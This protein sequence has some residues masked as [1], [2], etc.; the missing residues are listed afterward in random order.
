MQNSS[1]RPHA[2]ENTVIVIDSFKGL[3]HIY[4]ANKPLYNMKPRAA[5]FQRSTI[6]T[7]C[8]FREDKLFIEVLS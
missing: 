4:L 3:L 1:E 7:I 6:K 2:L 8:T 5:D